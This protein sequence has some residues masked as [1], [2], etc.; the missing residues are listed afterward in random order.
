MVWPSSASAAPRLIAVVV[1]PT[2][3]FWLTTAMTGGVVVA[4]ILGLALSNDAISGGI[5]G[6]LVQGDRIV[7]PAVKGCPRRAQAR[8]TVVRAEDRTPL[9]GALPLPGR[10]LPR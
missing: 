2:P 6:I 7:R 9:A 1:F 10:C 4:N 3:P 8:I 5:S